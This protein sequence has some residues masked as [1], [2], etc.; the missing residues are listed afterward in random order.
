MPLLSLTYTVLTTI[1]PP[2]LHNLISVQF[3]PPCSTRS[4]SLVT[5]ARPPTSS[6][7]RITDRSFRY[8]I[9][10]LLLSVNLIPALA[11]TCLF[12]L[13]P[14]LLTLSTHHSHHPITSSIF[15]S[16]LKPTSFKNPSHH[17][18]SSGLR[19]DST[20]FMTGPFLL[21]ILISVF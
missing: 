5:L 12:L 19:T 10:S 7:L 6:S 18:F 15:H 1:Q 17:R 20:D 13:L 4:S 21:S 8:E 2:Y 3:Q 14:H 11:L 9:N 16:R